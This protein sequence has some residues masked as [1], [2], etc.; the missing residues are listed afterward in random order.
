MTTNDMETQA[1]EQN[2]VYEL[3]YPIGA[4]AF[5]WADLILNAI[6][7]KVAL[8]DGADRSDPRILLLI[9]PMIVTMLCLNRQV[10]FAEHLGYV[11]ILCIVGLVLFLTHEGIAEGHRPAI[12]VTVFALVWHVIYG[13][14]IRSYQRSKEKLR[15]LQAISELLSA[16]S[17]DD[18]AESKQTP[19]NLP[20]S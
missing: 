10:P 7:V 17:A 9:L 16:E 20:E 11:R 5:F 1:L 4:K 12:V 19:S 6:I 15:A 8:A 13:L 2:L 14:C 18:D 3:R